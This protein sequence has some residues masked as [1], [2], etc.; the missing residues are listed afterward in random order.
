MNNTSMFKILWA[1]SPAKFFLGLSVITLF[2]LSSCNKSSILGLEVQPEDDLINAAFQDT[3]TL[4]TQTI[5]EDTLKTSG[6]PYTTWIGKYVD[7]IFGEV[8]VSTYTQ[9]HMFANNPSFGKKPICDSVVLRLVYAT[10]P[11]GKKS[12][13]EQLMSV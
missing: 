9:M 11:Y 6:V 2:T 4:N 5:K 12:R 10:I 8:T 3:L 13:K 7:P 1:S